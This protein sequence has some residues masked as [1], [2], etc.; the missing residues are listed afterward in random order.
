MALVSSL[1][2]SAPGTPHTRHALWRTF[3]RFSQ[4]CTVSLTTGLL[5]SPFNFNF[6]PRRFRIHPVLLTPPSCLLHRMTNTRCFPNGIYFNDRAQ[7]QLILAG[8][9]TTI[10]RRN[11]SAGK[12]VN[13]YSYIQ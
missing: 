6:T 3:L 8:L 13:R 2:E 7:F 5:H 11:A 10:L 4:L 12:K 9:I 1:V